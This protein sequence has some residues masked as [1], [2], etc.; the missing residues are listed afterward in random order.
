M[1]FFYHFQPESS[2]ST[3]V[4]IDPKLLYDLAGIARMWMPLSKL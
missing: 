4:G 3:D 2:I 1:V